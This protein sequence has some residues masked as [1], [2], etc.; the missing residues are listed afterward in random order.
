M[1]QEGLG[2]EAYANLPKPGYS[3]YVRTAYADEDLG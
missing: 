3:K 2:A 1:Q